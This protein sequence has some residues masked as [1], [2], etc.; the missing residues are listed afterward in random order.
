MRGLWAVGVG[1]LAF[2]TVAVLGGSAAGGSF[3]SL[4]LGYG[5]LVAL[6]S[7]YML[8]GLAIRDRVWRRMRRPAVERIQ[9]VDLAGRRVF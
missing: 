1:G 5:M 3:G 4:V 6:A 2:G 8:A 7:L 9:P